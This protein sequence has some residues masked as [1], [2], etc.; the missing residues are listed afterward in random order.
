MSGRSVTP[1]LEWSLWVGKVPAGL[2]G[3]STSLQ[4]G[5]AVIRSKSKGDILAQQHSGSTPTRAIR[6]HNTDILSH[7][8]PLGSRNPILPAGWSVDQPLSS[9]RQ[10]STVPT[11]G[12]VFG[13]AWGTK[14]TSLPP[15]SSTPDGG[16][17]PSH[18]FA[19][20][21]AESFSQLWDSEGQLD[22]S[23]PSTPSLTFSPESIELNS[24]G[25]RTIQMSSFIDVYTPPNGYIAP[26]TQM[27]KAD[28]AT[29]LPPHISLSRDF[30]NWKLGL[31]DSAHYNG[32][33]LPFM[34]RDDA[35][36]TICVY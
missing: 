35:I 6:R 4:S 31:S 32:V 13:E 5:R 24:D 8:E 18:E 22:S 7:M 14:P 11:G 3:L 33:S 30:S 36:N 26:G 1:L 28:S 16:G 19:H 20:V 34:D 15:L 25:D 10:C 9:L 2:T 27:Q 12:S 29:E 23:T 17:P 21:V